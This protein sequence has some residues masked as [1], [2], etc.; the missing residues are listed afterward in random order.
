MK[1]MKIEKQIIEILGKND[2]ALSPAE[3]AKHLQL[4]GQMRKKLK[5]HLNQLVSHGDI[6]CIRQGRYSLGK[7][8]DLF[9]GRL[10]SVRSGNGFVDAIDGET[11]KSVFVASRDMAKALSG[12]TVMVRIYPERAEDSKGR[13]GKI[14]RIIERGRHDIVGTLRSTGRFMNVVPIDP[15]YTQNFYVTDAKG[16]KVG[17]RVLIR[18]SNWEN[19]HVSPEAKVLEVLGSADNPSVDTISI[20]KHHDLHD[21]FADEVLR[22]AE[23]ASAAMEFP[24]KRVDLRNDLIITID[25]DSSRDFDDALSLEKDGNDRVLGVHIADVSHFVQPGSA[26]DKEARDRGTS[27]YL[28]D[29]VL[30][31]LPV[32][33]SN[34]ICSLNPNKDRLAFSVMMKLDSDGKIVKRWF[35]KTIIN[36]SAR[37]TYHNALAVIEGKGGGKAAGKIPKNVSKLIKDLHTLAQQFRARRFANSALDLD[38]PEIEI[39]TD[40]SGT[41]TGIR[42]V[43]ND[44]SHQL[45]EECMVAANEAVATELAER[46]IPSLAR[47][48]DE[49]KLSKIEDLIDLLMGMGYSPGDLSKQKNMS[50][51]VKKIKAD[52]LAHHVHIA[53]LKSMNRAIYSSTQTGHYGLAKTYYS[54]FT[55]PIRRYPD[56]VVHR[57]LAACLSAPGGSKYSKAQL[58]AIAS[59]CSEREHVAD[60][61]E[62]ALTEIMKFRYL[63]REIAKDEKTPY[64]AVIV[65]VT[66]FGVFAEMES[67]RVQGLIPI[68]DLSKDFLHFNRQTKELSNKRDRFRVGDRMKVCITEVDLDSRRL[69][70]EKA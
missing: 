32:Q 35:A 59:H 2:R 48:H 41:M 45:V 50:E 30:P 33:L 6:V 52:P 34:G 60:Q 18:F 61:A 46:N 9:T 55:S 26:L 10:T 11:G 68:A 43:V 14:I 37:L 44:V 13:S 25:P 22:E 62:R 23:A 63:E 53:V 66:N 21:E 70:F 29:K 39:V 47:F 40:G 27:V 28:P 24:G 19:R 56:L 12:D 65:A 36:S 1:T 51:F 38:V 58:A 64:E 57:Q 20:I 54:H 7:E 8:A 31:M 42:P 16:A 17:D 67:F 49:P 15:S 3:I 5:R 4:R 69:T